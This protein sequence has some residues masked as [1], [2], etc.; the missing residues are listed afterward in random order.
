M[1]PIPFVAPIARALLR[2]QSDERLVALARSGHH[3]AFEEIVRRYRSPLVAFA[4]AFAPADRAEDVVQESLAKA[5]GAL[6]GSERE[7]TLKPWLY[8][9]VRNRALNARRDARYHSELDETID[10]VR[11]PDEIV[12]QRDELNRAVAAI[13]ALPEAQRKALVDSAIEGRTHDQ[14]AAELG[15]SPDSVRGLIHRGRVAVR[16][17]AGS[18]VPAPVLAWA[19]GAGG[20]A[21]GGVAAGGVV[22]GSLAGKGIA[23]AAIAALATGS[24]LVVERSLNESAK[25]DREAGAAEARGDDRR[26]GSKRRGRLEPPEDRHAPQ[27]A[28]GGSEEDTSG[29]ERDGRAEGSGS[30]PGDGDDDNSGPGGGDDS[31]HDDGDDSSGLGSGHEGPDDSSGP[32][33]GDDD[34]GSSGSGSG[35]DSS[36]SS[37]SGGGGSSGSGSGSDDDDSSGS[38]SGGSGS[39]DDSEPDDLELE[40]D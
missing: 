36:G 17:A 6:E 22:G 35:H 20:T 33:P 4:A 18:L 5:W 7:I 25:T 19:A 21:A 16:G 32:G 1:T 39:D 15:T 23:V 34:D 40:D 8:T 2:S 9:I 31:G 11:R 13:A 37:G 24:G 38:G 3:G 28:G 26:G 14:I 30:G 27:G 12:L 10:G 29:P